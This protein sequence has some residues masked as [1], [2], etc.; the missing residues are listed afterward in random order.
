MNRCCRKAASHLLPFL[1]EIAHFT[2]QKDVQA[3]LISL[4]A[5]GV[6]LNLTQ[7]DYV[8]II[9][10]WWNPAAESQAIA[11]AHRIGQDKQVIAYR[12]I[13]QNS[14]EEKILYLQD[15]KRKLAETFVTD[16]ETLPALSNEQWVDLL[17]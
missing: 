14:I 10:P 15:E 12:F 17:K 13:T 7:A 11:R 5:G 8:F 2:E 6:G 9:D 3:F 16:S 4:K 1:H